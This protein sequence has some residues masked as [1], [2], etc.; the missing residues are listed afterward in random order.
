MVKGLKMDKLDQ[1]DQLDRLEQFLK[2]MEDP[3][4]IAVLKRLKDK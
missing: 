1:L 2:R 3:E 4:I